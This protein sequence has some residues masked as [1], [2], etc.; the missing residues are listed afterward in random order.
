MSDVGA[1]AYFL[2]RFRL[3][4]MRLQPPAYGQEAQPLQPPPCRRIY[5]TDS[6]SKTR[7]IAIS[8]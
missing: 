8:A 3:A 7:M 4:R 2:M 1:S 5:H 6:P